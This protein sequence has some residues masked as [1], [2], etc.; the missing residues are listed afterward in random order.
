MSEWFASRFLKFL[1]PA[2]RPM[3]NMPAGWDRPQEDEWALCNLGVPSPYLTVAFPNH[4]PQYPEYLTLEGV[5]PQELKRWKKALHRFLRQVTYRKPGRLILKSP[6]HTCRI[7]VLLEMFPDARFV[8]IVRDP[9]TSLTS[10][11]SLWK[12]LYER[13]SLQKPTYEGLEQYV[14]DNFERMYDRFE[15][16]RHLIAPG[17]LCEL[18]YEDL[19]REPLAQ[20][21]KIYRQLD[22]GDFEPARPEVEQYLTE[23]ADYQTNRH[24]VPAEFRREIANRCRVFMRRYGY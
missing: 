7:R 23:V 22:L 10:T 19:V 9:R 14:F 2:R 20:V 4:S 15:A 5:P 21:E 18:L 24:E 1:L 6:T 13:Q 16:D 3:D 8:H 17:R 11:L 12:R